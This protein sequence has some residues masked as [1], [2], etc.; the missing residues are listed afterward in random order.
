MRNFKYL[1]LISTLGIISL[2][3]VASADY[4]AKSG[5]RKIAYAPHQTVSMSHVSPKKAVDIA[6]TSNNLSQFSVEAIIKKVQAIPQ[7]RQGMIAA[8]WPGGG[9]TRTPGVVGSTPPTLCCPPET[10]RSAALA[11]LSSAAP[12]RKTTGASSC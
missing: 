12:P 7:D 5:K 10:G 6:F 2:A 9:A 11:S 4:N 3:S 8:G 1:K